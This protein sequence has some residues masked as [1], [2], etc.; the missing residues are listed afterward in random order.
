MAGDA[1]YADVV[2]LLKADG[3]N[4]STTFTDS[5]PSP[6]TATAYGNAAIST[7]QSKF[8]GSSIAFDGTDDYLLLDGSS[9]LALGT[10]DFTIE[11]WVYQGTLGSGMLMDFRP[12]GTNGAYPTFSVTAT[13]F[14]YSANSAEH[15]LT[16]HG[17]SAGAWAHIAVVRSSGVTKVYVDG[18]QKGGSYTDSTNYQ[19]GASRPVIGANGFNLSL[20]HLNGYVDDVRITKGVARYTANFTPPAATFPAYVAQ[21]SGT[22]L[23]TTNS[24]A[25][26]T[27][28]AYRR[29]TG[30]LVGSTTSNGT[31]GA[32]SMDL[33]TGEEVTVLALDN[34]TTGSYYNDIAIRV[35]P[36]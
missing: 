25:A 1:N 5:S 20:T 35:I 21:V 7:T 9:N 32:Y 13:D 18:V 26:R 30:A 28:R 22:V 12:N 16:A 10:G 4:G 8:G 36:A 14:S 34:Q 24:P 3:T 15:I 23:D 33:P 11:M 29:D 27:V 31:T 6:R 19:C 2:L 17:L